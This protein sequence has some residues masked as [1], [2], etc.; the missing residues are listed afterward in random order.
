MEL[1]DLGRPPSVS[2]PSNVSWSDTLRRVLPAIVV[3]RCNNVRQFNG[4]SASYS[5]ATG[6]VVDAKR[7][8]I[9]SNRHV[10]TTGPISAEAMFQNKE[11]VN[12]RPIYRD[13]VHDFGFFHFD[14]KDVKFLDLQEIKLA[15][16]EARVGVEIRVV[17]VSAR[18]SY[19]CCFLTFN[20]IQ[21]NLRPFLFLFR[22]MMLE[23]SF[24]SYPAP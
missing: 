8:I 6:F 2:V 19:C 15:P 1:E 20:F 16:Q 14:P 24:P 4:S 13:P 12:V 11:E 21:L 17:G 23:K 3:L 22:R 18:S 7:G 9:I 5:Y 10:V